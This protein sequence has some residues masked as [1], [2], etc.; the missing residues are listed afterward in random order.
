MTDSSQ[1]QKKIENIFQVQKLLLLVILVLLV[2]KPIPIG[3]GGFGIV[4]KAETNDKKPVALKGLISSVIDE[5]IIKNFVKEL[6][7]LRMVS[8][9]DNINRFLGITKVKWADNTG[10]IMIQMALDITHGLLC[11]HLRNIIHRDLHSKNILVNDGKLLIADFGLSKQLTEVTSNSTRE[12][13]NMLNY[14]ITSGWPPFCTVERDM[15]GY[16][17]SHEKN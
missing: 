12:L 13:L 10:Y 11:L 2:L 6:K 1:N 14:N 8:Y 17:I 16:H 15:L 7:L 5:N 9:H 4:Y 3:K